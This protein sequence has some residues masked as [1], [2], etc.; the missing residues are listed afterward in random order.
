M[1]LEH[2]RE[3]QEAA[4]VG[5]KAGHRSRQAERAAP[6]TPDGSRED[7]SGV[8]SL[9]GSAIKRASGKDCHG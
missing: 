8:Q 3:F 5:K 6:S 1:A 4:T 9:V 2:F 7:S